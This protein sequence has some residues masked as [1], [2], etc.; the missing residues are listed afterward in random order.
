MMEIKGL[1]SMRK[2]LAKEQ[3]GASKHIEARSLWQNQSLLE[4]N[5]QINKRDS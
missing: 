1:K 4:I 3:N 5:K 2:Q